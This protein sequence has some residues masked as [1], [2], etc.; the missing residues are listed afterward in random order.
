MQ[1]A[2]ARGDLQG[3]LSERE[4]LPP[5]AQ[6]VSATWAGAAT[7]RVAI[8]TIVERLALSVTPPAN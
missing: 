1:A 3:A 2:V 7:D 8:D 6:D 5:A 4:K